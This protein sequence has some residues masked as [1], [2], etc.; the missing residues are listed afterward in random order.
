[1]AR[2]PGTGRPA[3]PSLSPDGEEG[4]WSPPLIPAPPQKFIP[5]AC[6][7]P[8]YSLPSPFLQ[9]SWTNP[10]HAKGAREGR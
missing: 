6:V 3:H 8:V 5:S 9:V 10:T 4:V 1:V 2:V 7:L